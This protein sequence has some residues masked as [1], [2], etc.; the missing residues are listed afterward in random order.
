MNDPLELRLKDDGE[1]V[2][3]DW[4]AVSNLSL[5]EIG[6]IVCISAMSSMAG[7]NSDKLGERFSESEVLTCL[8]SL[9]DKGVLTVSI[10]N[11]GNV[12]MN[13]DLDVVAPE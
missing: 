8:K 4:I 5:A 9:K 7:G 1:I 12:K 13:L 11:L 10:E 2:L 6:T 3:P